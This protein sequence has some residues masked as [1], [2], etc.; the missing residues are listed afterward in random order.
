ME[1][2]IFALGADLVETV[3]QR[4][5][6]PDPQLYLGSGKIEEARRTRAAFGADLVVV[7]AALKPGQ[8]FSLRQAFREGA[9]EDADRIE[10][11]DRTRLI[12]EIFRERARSPEARLQVELA[13]IQYEIPLVKE[14]IHLEKRGER[15]AAMFGGGQYGV[16][17]YYDMMKRRMVRIRRDLDKM[18]R[19][20]DLRRKHR[21]RGGFH[22]VSLA[23]YTNAGKSSLLKALS[24]RHALVENRYFSTLST[25]TARAQSDRREI[26]VTDTVGFIEDLPPWMVEAFHSTLEEIAL[27]DVILLV[28]DASDP[29]EEMA[30][31]LRSSLRVLWEFDG[32]GGSGVGPARGDVGASFSSLPSAPAGSLP[33]SPSPHDA[34][35]PGSPS[36]SEARTS[37]P[38]S[39]P[40]SPRVSSSPGGPTPSDG[41]SPAASPAAS[42]LTG[43]EGAR[44]FFPTRR[45]LAPIL[46]ALNKVD[47]VPR[48]EL[49]EKRQRLEDEGLLPPGGWVALSARTGQGLPELYERL[50]ALIPDYDEFEVCLLPTPEAEAFIGWLH[51]N[52]DV[53]DLTRGNEVH[54]HF[55][56]KRSLRAELQKRLAAAGAAPLKEVQRR[57]DDPSLPGAA[58]AG[59]MDEERPGG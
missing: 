29:A 18:R 51:E 28:V 8:I 3:Y 21:R 38:P 34:T 4:R 44:V 58:T 25:K 24:E 40:S 49:E 32:N 5:P 30:R 26:L 45:G 15:Q 41:T 11:Y 56:A 31:R 53:L 1:E 59:T 6:Q 14:A 2:L 12:L 37:S 22:L 20:R 23:G 54:L 35:M 16:N 50:Y 36:P 57:L 55:E 43:G 46:V 52:A 13:T 39:S 42:A 27:A 17:E 7:N 48:A 19:E 33:S 10:V 47:A 9:G